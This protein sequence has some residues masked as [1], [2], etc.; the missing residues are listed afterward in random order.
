MDIFDEV[1]MES[2]KLDDHSRDHIMSAKAQD[3]EIGIRRLKSMRSAVDEVPIG[4]DCGEWCTIPKPELH[5]AH[6]ASS[7][8]VRRLH[9]LPA[10]HLFLE[11]TAT[12]LL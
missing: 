2:S 12:A 8:Q 3:A 10:C 5:S 11:W 6:N 9:T 1:E 7:P 4:A